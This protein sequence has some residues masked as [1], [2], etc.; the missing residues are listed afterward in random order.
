MPKVRQINYDTNE[1]NY[2]Q[3]INNMS[4]GKEALTNL[5]NGY[6]LIGLGEIFTNVTIGINWLGIIRDGDVDNIVFA[7][8][9]SLIRF[10]QINP[11]WGIYDIFVTLKSFDMAQKQVDLEIKLQSNV[12]EVIINV[13][14]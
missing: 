12:G 6:L 3:G 8:R 13:N 11:K 4:T 1:P 10:K 2:F 7:V 5:L 9:Q 14:Q